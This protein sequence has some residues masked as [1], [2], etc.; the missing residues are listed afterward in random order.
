MTVNRIAPEW[1]QQ[2]AVIIVWPHRHSDWRDCLDAIEKTHLELARHIGRHQRLILVAYNTAHV[3]HIRHQLEKHAINTANITFTTIPTNDIWVR[4]YGPLCIA[5]G[6]ILLDF[7]FDGWGERYA[8]ERDNAFS[9]KLM[10]RLR[11]NAGHNRIDQVLEGGNVEING[12][13]EVLCSSSCLRR[14]GADFDAITLEEKFTG[15][16][17]SSKTHWIDT[18]PLQGDDT[19]GHIDTLARFCGDDVIAHAAPGC[20]NDP[21]GETLERLIIQLRCL[22]SDGIDLVPLPL[23]APIFLSG[24]PIPASYTNFLITNQSVL[25]PTFN[26]KQDEP[27]LKIF[28]ELFPTRAIIAIDGNTLARQ[29]GGI[30]CATLQLPKGTLG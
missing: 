30:H 6:H 26:D 28:E 1:Q 18:A 12:R 11:L 25:V 2:D 9:T 15:W 16:F 4:D 7:A 21:N 10:E 20:G 17:G 5:S 8:Y 14:N 3:S 22:Q 23:P 27:T 19:D 24:K 29:C 13:G